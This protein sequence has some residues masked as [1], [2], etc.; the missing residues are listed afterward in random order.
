MYAARMTDFPA[1]LPHGPITEVFPDVFLVTGSFRFAPGLTITRNM[2]VVR[3]GGELVLVGSVRLSPEGEARLAELGKVTHVLRIGAFHGIDD[4][5]TKQRF[6][7]Q[8]WAPPGT[9]PRGGVAAEQE[10]RPG[11]SPLEGAQVFAFERGRQP[12]VAI[13]L[14]REGGILLTCDSY[15]NWTTFDG[16]SLLG[17]VMMK[18]MGFG[19]ALIGGPWLKAMGPE[20]RADFD[21]LIEVPFRHLLSAHGTPLRDSA[22]EGLKRAIA[23]RF[24]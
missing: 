15:Q 18:A 7:A 20:V 21:R 4:P 9:K 10:L 12:E 16:C 1:A 11:H 2:V 19:P 5:Y 8:L 6:G 23:H 24:A 22:Q 17:R 14:E 13:L 3:Q